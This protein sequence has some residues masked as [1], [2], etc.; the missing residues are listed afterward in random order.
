MRP[1]PPE[2]QA[3]AVSDVFSVDQPQHVRWNELMTSDP[4]GAAGFYRRHL[5]RKQEGSI[6]M[7]PLGD[8][9]FI[10]HGELGIGAIMRLMQ[11]ASRPQWTCYVGV[12]DID[13]AFA[14]V[15]AGGGK[16]L[17]G[18]SQIPGSEYSLT[19]VDPQGA[20]FGLVG[21]RQAAQS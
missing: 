1:T 4:T 8:Y 17:A 15:E 2:G 19:A 12:A 7:G 14:A 16:V 10:Q 21:P 5:G 6:P 11:A 20:S 18:P 3:H 9:Q 13:S